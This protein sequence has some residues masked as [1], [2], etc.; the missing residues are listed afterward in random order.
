MGSQTHRDC[1]G[2]KVHSIF[3]YNLQHC[4]LLVDNICTCCIYSVSNKACVNSNGLQQQAAD[5]TGTSKPQQ[6]F[7][8]TSSKGCIMVLH[9]MRQCGISAAELLQRFVITQ[10]SQHCLG[11]A[12][13]HAPLIVSCEQPTNQLSILCSNG[14]AVHCGASAQAT[15]TSG[16]MQSGSIYKPTAGTI[17]CN[18]AM[19]ST[20]MTYGHLEGL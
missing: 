11:A 2:N 12:K 14:G 5:S 17:E 15:A 8:A 9:R 4:S 19:I 20:V 6:A 10:H 16:M 3:S 1:V 13:R 7:A 18:P